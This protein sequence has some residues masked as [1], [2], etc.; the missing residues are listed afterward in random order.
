MYATYLLPI[1]LAP[2]LP[3]STAFLHFALT[4][5]LTLLV[6]K[7]IPFS[8]VIIQSLNIAWWYCIKDNEISLYCYLLLKS[9]LIYILDLCCIFWVVFV[10]CNYGTNS[11]S[12]YNLL[13]RTNCIVKCHFL[14]C[15]CTQWC[16]NSPC[17]YVGNVIILFVSLCLVILFCITYFLVSSGF[18]RT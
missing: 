8:Q 7:S 2:R 12:S 4:N 16:A 1:L 5:V 17:T 9:F 6:C 18:K 15:Y 3:C 14:G 13:P 10:L 11:Q